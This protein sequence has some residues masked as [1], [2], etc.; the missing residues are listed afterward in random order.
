MNTLLSCPSAT[1]FV[2]GYMAVLSFFDSDMD[3]PYEI[4]GSMVVGRENSNR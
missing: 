1:V 4:I 3:N 2:M